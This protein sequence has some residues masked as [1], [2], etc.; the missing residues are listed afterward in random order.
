MSGTEPDRKLP[1]HPESS[2]M[3]AD[4]IRDITDFLKLALPSR[5]APGVHGELQITVK[6]HDGKL[7]LVETGIGQKKHY[8]Y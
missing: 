5:F 1:K 4:A 3:T 7:A 6:V 8:K 2:L